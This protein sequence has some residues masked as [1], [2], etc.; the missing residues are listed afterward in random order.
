MVGWYKGK[1]NEDTQK[2]KLAPRRISWEFDMVWNCER[3]D[4]NVF[5]VLS[6]LV[7]I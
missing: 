7:P 3:D 2:V 5:K 6:K 1:Q 4:Q